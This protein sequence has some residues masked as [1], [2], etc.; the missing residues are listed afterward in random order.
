[1]EFRSA[2]KGYVLTKLSNNLREKEIYRPEIGKQKS[3]RILDRTY[4]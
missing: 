2:L 4:L 1:M 3:I